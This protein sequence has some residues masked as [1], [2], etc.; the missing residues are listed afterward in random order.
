MNVVAKESQLVQQS[1]NPA[2]MAPDR[3][4][5]TTTLQQ[6][7]EQLRREKDLALQRVGSAARGSTSGVDPSSIRVSELEAQIEELMRE[8]ASLALRAKEADDA[9]SLR[10]QVE[11]L[12]RQ[13]ALLQQQQQQAVESRD[14]RLS[15]GAIRQALNRRTLVDG[16][17][18][19]DLTQFRPAGAP[20]DGIRARA[21]SSVVSTFD[22]TGVDDIDS[23]EDRR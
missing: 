18:L 14:A 9:L 19:V 7:I 1:A 22:L 2:S 8:K 10:R 13:N 4:A 3:A 6:K 20:T 16:K 21:R 17:R 15:D 11:E 23:D 12:E 5:D